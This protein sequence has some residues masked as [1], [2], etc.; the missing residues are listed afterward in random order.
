MI[1]RIQTTA[2]LNLRTD[3]IVPMPTCLP[4]IEE[5]G[6]PVLLDSPSAVG[7]SATK[8]ILVIDHDPEVREL[9][10]K[11]ITRA[12]FRADIE[13]D[14]EEGWHALCRV[15][16]DLVITGNEMPGLT[17]VKLIERIRGFSK[18]PPCMLISGKQSGVESTLMPLIGFDGFLAKPFSPAALIEKVYDLLLHGQSMEP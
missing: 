4:D 15:T 9:V 10:A 7:A 3:E 16:Y 14:G 11:T 2:D 17:G 18:E 6:G 12:G 13:S 8:Q 5:A 1:K